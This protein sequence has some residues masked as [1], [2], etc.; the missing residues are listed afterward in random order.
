MTFGKLGYESARYR[1]TFEQAAY[2]L[3]ALA[4]AAI[5]VT[6]QVADA[7]ET[8]QATASREFEVVL[9][10]VG[11]ALVYA[12]LTSLGAPFTIRWAGHIAQQASQ[13]VAADAGTSEDRVLFF[14]LLGTLAMNAIATPLNFAIGIYSG[15]AQV[16]AERG[17]NVV[18]FTLTAL[19]GGAVFY[20]S[21]A[22]LQRRSLART[23]SLAVVAVQY[24]RPLFTLLMLWC[25]DMATGWT[26]HW[27]GTDIRW[28]YFAIGAGAVMVSNILC[29]VRTN[30]ST[31]RPG[32]KTTSERGRR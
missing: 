26:G 2:M 4:G 7:G 17:G 15:E 8:T 9:I 31:A 21:A 19:A 30:R 29:G 3:V 1:A 28:D 27:L 22:L 32:S 25:I 10:G 20:A 5:V 24:L 16:L 12:A 23:R 6:S 14:A 11:W 18:Q 13:H